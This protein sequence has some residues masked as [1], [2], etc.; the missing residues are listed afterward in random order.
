MNTNLNM[1][2]INSTNTQMYIKAGGGRDLDDDFDPS[3]L[4]F[5]WS[6]TS[7]VKETM[8]INLEFNQPLEISPMII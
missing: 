4:N 1:S 5:T 2:D 6:V 7:F 3:T 8:L